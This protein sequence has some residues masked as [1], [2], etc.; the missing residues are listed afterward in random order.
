MNLNQGNYC[1]KF[2]LSEFRNSGLDKKREVLQQFPTLRLFTLHISKNRCRSTLLFALT[3]S[4]L[5]SY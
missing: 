5:L 2:L 3:F 4:I 1:L